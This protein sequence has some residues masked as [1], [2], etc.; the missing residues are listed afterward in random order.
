V[1]KTAVVAQTSKTSTVISGGYGS[2]K[3]KNYFVFKRLYGTNMILD[4]FTQ[5]HAQF[6][7]KSSISIA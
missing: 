3:R 1:L 5:N 6:H 2:S 7:L 4:D